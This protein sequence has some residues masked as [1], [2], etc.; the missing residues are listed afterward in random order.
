MSGILHSMS[1]TQLE[2][3]NQPVMKHELA[4]QKRLRG[5]LRSAAEKRGK[6]AKTKLEQQLEIQHKTGE[7]VRRVE[8]FMEDERARMEEMRVIVVAVAVALT[9]T[10]AAWLPLMCDVPVSEVMMLC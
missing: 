9:R 8:H 3:L 5:G 1:A 10:A 4:K 2:L 6:K 7:A